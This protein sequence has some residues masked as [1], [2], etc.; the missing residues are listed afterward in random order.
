MPRYYLSFAEARRWAEKGQ[1]PWTPA[2][3]VFF[4]LR[5]GVRRLRAEGREAT[6]ARHRA[7]A[8]GARAGLEALGLSL[9]APEAYRSPTVTAAWLP[10]GLEWAPFNADMRSRGL[11]V[12]GGQDRMAGRILRFGH[13]GMV[14]PA[15][16]ADAVRVM[17]ETLRDHGYSVDPAAAVAATLSAAETALGAA[18]GAR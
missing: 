6:W 3:A 14:E 16:L 13:M 4:G 7:V 5:V 18:A 8:A 1:T 17:G 15:D 10:E 2:V 12:A 9:V 11:V